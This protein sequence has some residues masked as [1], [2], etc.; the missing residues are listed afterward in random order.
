MDVSD[1]INVKQIVKSPIRPSSYCG[2]NIIKAQQTHLLDINDIIDLSFFVLTHHFSRKTDFNLLH[3][4][5]LMR[6]NR[7]KSTDR[8]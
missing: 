5:K 3:R 7:V 2:A 8:L 4:T 1:T 6:S